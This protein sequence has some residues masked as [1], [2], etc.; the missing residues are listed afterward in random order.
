MD[1]PAVLLGTVCGVL[2]VLGVLGVVAGAWWFSK[3]KRGRVRKVQE[4]RGEETGEPRG[5]IDKTPLVWVM[6]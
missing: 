4:N 5:E 3:F 1:S 2:G 6:E